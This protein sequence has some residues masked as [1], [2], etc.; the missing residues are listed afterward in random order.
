MGTLMY[1]T[2]IPHISEHFQYEQYWSHYH[3]QMKVKLGHVRIWL[4]VCKDDQKFNTI[5]GIY[6]NFLVGVL[7]SYKIY[8]EM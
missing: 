2:Q 5:Y 3:P 6:Y 1:T 4:R 7:M 8:F